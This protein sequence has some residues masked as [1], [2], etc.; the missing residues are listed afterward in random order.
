[1]KNKYIFS[2]S[3]QNNRVLSDSYKYGHDLSIVSIEE[4]DRPPYCYFTSP[5]LSNLDE[6]KEI[7]GRALSLIN[8]YNGASNLNFN[9]ENEIADI[10]DL[11][12]VKMFIWENYKDITPFD[13]DDIIQSY[14]F[15]NKVI[16]DEKVLSKTNR[17]AYL[18][19]LAK[20]K[21]DILYILL[22]LG[23]GLTWINL[24]S[25]YDSIK[26]FSYEIDEKHFESVVT[27]S[28][29]S[30]ADLKAFTGTAN[31]FGFLGVDARHG[32]LGYGTPKKTLTLKESQK[33]IISLCNSYIDLKYF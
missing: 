15:D 6:P 26:T 17:N 25:I 23:N 1:M 21:K 18:I 32:E 8:L 20:S 33:L 11:K 31:N 29:N 28:G 3:Y 14:A 16:L 7:W 10:S 2:I 5:H 12:I 4:D 13:K 24:Y 9:P 27:N 30:I 19:N 22:Q